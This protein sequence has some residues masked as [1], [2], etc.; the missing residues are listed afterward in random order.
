M[1]REQPIN[2]YRISRSIFPMTSTMRRSTG[3][4]VDVSARLAQIPVD[5]PLSTTPLNPM[6]YAHTY[7]KPKRRGRKKYAHPAARQL[8]D[9]AT[10]TPGY[11]A[12]Y[13]LSAITFRQSRKS[14]DS[15]K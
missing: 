10:R 13:G 6:H 2:G 14:K 7:R 4:T 12:R 1:Y 5:T 8:P 15:R 9:P 11:G 3:A